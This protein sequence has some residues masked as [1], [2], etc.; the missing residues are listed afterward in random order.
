[1]KKKEKKQKPLV[2]EVLGK[3]PAKT[4][5]KNLLTVKKTTSLPAV[6]A[7]SSLS[8]KDP[9][10]RYLE[11][12][13]RYEV[14]SPEEQQEMAAKFKETGDIT[15]AKKLVTTIERMWN[16]IKYASTM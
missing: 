13:R 1:M 16:V 9:L 7:P 2:P 10:A 8:V 3:A 14:M 12:I 4:P 6:K 5:S 11:E 15:L